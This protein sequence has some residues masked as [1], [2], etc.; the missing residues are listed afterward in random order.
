ML[1]FY[2]PLLL[3]I[4]LIMLQATY[5]EKGKLAH[6][7]IVAI[8]FTISIILLFSSTY[9]LFLLIFINLFLYGMVCVC[10]FTRSTFK[11]F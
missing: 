10:Y 11:T 3:V 5:V 1:E 6:S 4:S 9:W 2:G 7:L 8:G